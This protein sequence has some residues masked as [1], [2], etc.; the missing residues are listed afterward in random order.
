MEDHPPKF[1][2][3]IRRDKMSE[4]RDRKDHEGKTL[5][6]IMHGL[7]PAQEYSLL[8]FFSVSM[9]RRKSRWTRCV[10]LKTSGIG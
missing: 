8:V 5:G 4:C 10:P 1:S 2:D 6:S 7:V 9:T 3:R